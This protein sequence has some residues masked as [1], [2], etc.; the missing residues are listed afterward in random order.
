MINS[1]GSE[2]WLREKVCNRKRNALPREEYVTTRELRD[3][4]NHNDYRT[5]NLLD[6]MCKYHETG[7]LCLHAD[8]VDLLFSLLDT[9]TILKSLVDQR[10]SRFLEKVL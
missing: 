5:L 2:K 10:R 9:G 4:K 8:W 6:I 7:T 3:C 1:D